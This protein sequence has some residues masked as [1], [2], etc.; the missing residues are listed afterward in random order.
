MKVRAKLQ[1]SNLFVNANG[2]TQI[3]LSA[4]YNN[5]DGTRAEEN[6]AF[7][8][9]TPIAEFSMTVTKG[10]PAADAFVAGL[11]YYVDFTPIPMKPVEVDVSG[12]DQTARSV[13]L[14]RIEEVIVD[15]DFYV[16]PGST[17]T[18]CM[19]TLSNGAK[20]LGHNYG[21]IDPTRQSWEKGCSEAR[22]MAVEKVWELEGYALRNALNPV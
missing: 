8:D 19:L 2:D 11:G 22:A 13:T 7:S 17:V 15:T 1:C 16:F 6:K 18:V 5:Q 20:V 21:S 12:Y 14:L 3:R 4:M 10:K 9:A